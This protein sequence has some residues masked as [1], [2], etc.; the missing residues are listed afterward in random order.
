MLL[1]SS[2]WKE[3][4]LGVLV[5]ATMGYVV[6]LKL[7][8]ARLREK[9][10]AA[11]AASKVLAEEYKGNILEFSKKRVITEVVYKDRIKVVERRVDV[12]S[13]CEDVMSS[14]DSYVY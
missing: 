6:V 14:F 7:D 11:D 10:A 9:V 4:V 1:L 3:L 5:I 12:N 13:S 2:Y 8:S